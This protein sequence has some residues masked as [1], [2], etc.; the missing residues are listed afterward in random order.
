MAS[1][2]DSDGQ[3]SLTTGALLTSSGDLCN[4]TF[5]FPYN[6]APICQ[7]T[8]ANAASGNLEATANGMYFTST[9]GTLSV[10]S[11][12]ALNADTYVWNY[13]CVETQ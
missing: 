8:A 10:N 9:T 13:H 4:V 11:V 1:A 2:T 5:N 12:T 6:V 7:V 3:I